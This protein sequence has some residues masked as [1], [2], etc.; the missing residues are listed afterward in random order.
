MSLRLLSSSILVEVVALWNSMEPSSLRLM[1]C[2]LF[3]ADDSWC[4]G[5]MSAQETYCLIAIQHICKDL[6]IG[7]ESTACIV[8]FANCLL[9]LAVLKHAS[10]SHFV[11]ATLP[12]NRRQPWH[13]PRPTLA[14]CRLQ[15]ATT[16]PAWRSWLSLRLFTPPS[17]HFGRHACL[18]TTCSLS[19]VLMFSPRPLLS[20][21]TY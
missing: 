17:S 19:R 2:Y 10:S 12:P 20:L 7:V 15:D 5:R 1:F 4:T 18:M 13:R 8:L 3:S 6:M 16:Q 11:A 9:H 14:K 21:P